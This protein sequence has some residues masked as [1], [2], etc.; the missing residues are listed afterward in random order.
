MSVK[1]GISLRP[2]PDPT[3]PSFRHLTHHI[4]SSSYR[5]AG[6]SSN[7]RGSL[8]SS[9]WDEIRIK[10]KPILIVSYIYSQPTGIIH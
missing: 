5:S 1:Y 7:S 6:K 4:M 8:L 10:A 2:G 9:T 3:I